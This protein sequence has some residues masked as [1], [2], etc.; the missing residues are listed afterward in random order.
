MSIQRVDAADGQRGD[1][2]QPHGWTVMAFQ[3]M[4]S[5]KYKIRILWDLRDGPRRYRVKSEPACS[6]PRRE[7]GKSRPACARAAS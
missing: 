2:A 7:P 3:A 4:I 6:A 1:P 5:G